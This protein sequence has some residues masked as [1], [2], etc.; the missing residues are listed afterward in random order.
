MSAKGTGQSGVRAMRVAQFGLA[1]RRW[2]SA[3]TAALISG[4]M[5]GT[6]GRM[7]KAEELSMTTAP[8]ST[9]TGAKR[10]ER[11]P[12]A[13]KKAISMPLSASSRS[14]RPPVC[15]RRR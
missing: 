3:S 13:E 15:D 9:S 11:L 5:R 12:P 4:T 14:S 8:R 2:S 7:R 1:I 6:S 10:L